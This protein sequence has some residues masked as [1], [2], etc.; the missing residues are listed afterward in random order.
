MLNTHI[1]SSTKFDVKLALIGTLQAHTLNDF[2]QP[3]S[4]DS[5]VGGHYDLLL[6]SV[7]PAEC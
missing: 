2:T 1:V 4:V 3:N 7:L 6:T 5:R